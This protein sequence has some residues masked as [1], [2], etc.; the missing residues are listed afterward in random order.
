MWTI[1]T[2]VTAVA[3][4]ALVIA[5]ANN[6]AAQTVIKF[7]HDQPESSSHHKAALKWKELVESRSNGQ[8]KVNIFPALLLGSATQMAEQVQ[9]GALEVAILPTA[10]LAPLAPSL[11]VLDLPFLF[12]TRDSLYKMIDGPVADELLK[13][14]NKVNI[15]GIAFWQSG[16]K[17]FTGHFRIREPGD[18]KGHKFRTM[19]AAVIQEQFRAFGSTPTVINFSELYSAL[20]QNVVDG[21][22]NPIETISLMRFHEVQ[23]YITISDHS[24]LAYVFLTNKPFFDKLPE[25]QRKIIVDAAKEA[26]KFQ[27]TLIED[28]EKHH[29]DVFRKAGLEITTLTPEQRAKFQEASRPV[30]DWFAKTYGGGPVEMIRKDVANQ[31]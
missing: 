24:F 31:K 29:L 14:L 21:Q 8:I 25:A 22:E 27:R 10:W 19:P 6:L 4:L 9:A 1:R 17:Q 23:K 30:Y 18:F 13:P 11:Q 7:G 28:A 15:Q 20:Q 3:T 26:G 5:G 2:F 12:P 16:F